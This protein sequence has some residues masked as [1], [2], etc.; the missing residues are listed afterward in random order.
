M[1]LSC[2]IAIPDWGADFQTITGKTSENVFVFSDNFDRN[3]GNPLTQR[4]V[5]DFEAKWQEPADFFSA[6]YYDAVYN[7]TAELIRRVVKKGGNPL[8]GAELEEAIWSKPSFN[9]V[10]G[11]ELILK[12]D[13]TVDKPMVIFKVT[14]GKLNFV[15]RM[16]GKE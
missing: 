4:F 16:T 9:T 11:G 10:Y 3:S 8:N 7:L 5:K 2:P 6:N 13:G 12:K 14:D 15:D 1:G